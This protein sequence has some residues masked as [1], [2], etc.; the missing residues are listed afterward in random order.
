MVS[1]K[2]QKLLGQ[3]GGCLFEGKCYFKVG[4]KCFRKQK[5][6]SKAGQKITPKRKKEQ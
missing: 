4:L 2:E 5:C 1:Q 3:W 6:N